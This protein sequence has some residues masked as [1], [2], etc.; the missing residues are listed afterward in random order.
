MK[1][2]SNN[3]ILFLLI[4]IASLTARAAVH[5]DRPVWTS[6]PNVSTTIDLSSYIENGITF[7]REI[8][9]EI[10]GWS[11][12][13]YQ[14]GFAEIAD[15]DGQFLKISTDAGSG[16]CEVR[17]IFQNVSA[18]SGYNY[19]QA[20]IALYDVWKENGYASIQTSIPYMPNSL[21]PYESS[22][23]W[24]DEVGCSFPR[25]FTVVL[26]HPAQG[27]GTGG[28]S[29]VRIIWADEDQPGH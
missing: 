19:C 12:S 11:T 10:M 25:A 7:F 17:M 2:T 24:F 8:R 29:Q 27:A 4:L 20:E 15:M 9:V 28:V 6:N 18:Y 5:E 3:G 13:P 21:L 1:K 26:R 23:S 14:G 22:A 16:D